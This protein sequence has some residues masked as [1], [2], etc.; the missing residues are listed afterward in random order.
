MRYFIVL[1]LLIYSLF[2]LS[3]NQVKL[4]QQVYTEAKK[5]KANDGFSFEKT[6][7]AIYITE[8][9]AGVKII[10]DKYTSTGILKPLYISSLGPGQIKLKTAL[11]VL[12]NFP[13]LKR[14]FHVRSHSVKIYETYSNLLLRLYKLKL[15]LN[16]LIRVQRY[17]QATDIMNQIYSVKHKLANYHSDILNDNKIINLLLTNIKF[18]VAISANY[19]IMTYEEAQRRH[20]WKPYLKAISRYNGGWYNYVYVRRVMRHLKFVKKLIK[21]GVIK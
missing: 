8:S 17:P 10:G 11:I 1:Q 15:K 14:K 5:Y 18:S 2:G 19:L 7:C 21:K 13:K 12:N 6:L 16:Y 4:L 9:S 20:M 3:T